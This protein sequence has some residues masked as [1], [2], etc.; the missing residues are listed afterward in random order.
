MKGNIELRAALSGSY[1]IRIIQN[2]AG[3]SGVNAVLAFQNRSVSAITH[4]LT[5][6]QTMTIPVG[7]VFHGGQR[8]YHVIVEHILPTGG[9]ND[10][11]YT[12]PIFIRQ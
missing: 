4:H 6:G 7:F 3:N 9:A 8:S 2:Y 11:I 1:R 10:T 12:S 5:A